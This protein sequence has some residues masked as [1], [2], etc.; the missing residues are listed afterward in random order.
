MPWEPIHKTPCAQAVEPNL[1]DYGE[2]RS[3]FTWD[4]ARSELDG[5]GVT[6]IVDET[7]PASSG[8]RLARSAGHRLHGFPE[9]RHRP[10]QQVGG[11]I[12][13]ADYPELSSIGSAVDYLASKI[14]AAAG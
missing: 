13:E 4:G 14:P 6:M 12:P 5:N 3:R 7:P 9:P 10:A 1:W 8:L 11:A 2:V